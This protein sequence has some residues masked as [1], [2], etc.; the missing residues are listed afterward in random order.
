MTE[1][2]DRSSEYPP[3]QNEKSRLLAAMKTVGTP[4]FLRSEYLDDNQKIERLDIFASEFLDSFVANA[5]ASQ[6]D[7]KTRK[8][9][10]L[11]V[12]GSP[13]SGK[14]YLTDNL[15]LPY[16]RTRAQRFYEGEEIETTIQH[17]QW[18]RLEQVLNDHHIITPIDRTG[19]FQ[20]EELETVSAFFSLLPAYVVAGNDLSDD[21]LRTQLIDRDYIPLLPHESDEAR[22]QHARNILKAVAKDL[23]LKGKEEAAHSLLVVEKPG[24]TAVKV[25]DFWLA[26]SRRYAPSLSEDMLNKNGAFCDIL[27]TMLTV[28]AVGVVGGPYMEVVDRGMDVTEGATINQLGKV[29]AAIYTAVRTFLTDKKHRLLIDELPENVANGIR[30]PMA[31]FSRQE[32]EIE[33]EYMNIA[34]KIA[35]SKKKD[36]RMIYINICSRLAES[37]VLRHTYTPENGRVVFPKRLT[38]L[39]FP[40]YVM[41]AFNNPS[42]E[43]LG[44]T[45]KI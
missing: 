1:H 39:N 27:H 44:N 41:I 5:R 13:V 38:D 19:P 8:T 24:V 23:G 4:P 9:H 33:D 12:D 34:K 36:P 3:S 11:I 14:T 20:Q 2:R 10:I 26:S 21:T 42:P 37:L 25:G 18:D 30:N 6:T 7:P 22:L 40:D 32:W 29:R 28:G 31:V 16:A 43:E 15:L 35:Q 17:L 45:L